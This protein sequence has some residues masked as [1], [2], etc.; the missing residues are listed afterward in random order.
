MPTLVEGV[1]RWVA[2]G[3]VVTGISLIRYSGRATT[4]YIKRSISALGGAFLWGYGGPVLAC[5]L[6]LMFFSRCWTMPFAHKP[7]LTFSRIHRPLPVPSFL[8]YK[9]RWLRGEQHVLIPAT[10]EH[11]T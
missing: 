7:N 4:T 6:V 10:S 8:R 9:M 5:Y 3:F 11:V 1:R 2:Q